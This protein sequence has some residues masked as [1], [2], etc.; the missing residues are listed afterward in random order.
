MRK[1][2]KIP[3]PFLY[4]VFLKKVIVLY[5]MLFPLFYK[6]HIFFVPVTAFNLCLLAI[7][8]LIA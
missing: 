7:I 2:K 5:A 4:S 8:E 3:I 6:E 1:D